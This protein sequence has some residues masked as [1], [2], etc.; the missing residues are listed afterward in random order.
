MTI[1]TTHKLLTDRWA[2]KVATLE[3]VLGRFSADGAMKNDCEIVFFEVVRDAHLHVDIM[4]RFQTST[5]P[6]WAGP[7]DL[8]G[9]CVHNRAFG[10]MRPSHLVRRVLEM[11]LASRIK[12]DQR[13]FGL[14]AS[15]Q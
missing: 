11:V 13:S 1:T 10:A 14:G 5:E 6:G 2:T 9:G 4:H 3:T 15:P 7:A 8:A 12:Q